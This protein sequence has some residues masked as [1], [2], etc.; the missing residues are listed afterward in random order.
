MP[1]IPIAAGVWPKTSVKDVAES[2][3]I[4]NLSD[5]AASALAADLEFRLNQIIEESIKFMRHAKRTKL[6]V[7][8]VD[9][10]LRAKN[11][12]PLW[13]FASTDTLSFRRTT[14][15][16][17][18]LYF[19]DDEEIDLTKIVNAQLPP[20]PRETSYTAHW[21]AVEGVQPAIP[22]N[23]SAAELK[24][25]PAF[26][27]YLSASRSDSKEEDEHKKMN[28]N[29]HLSRELRL[30][31]DRVTSA[32]SSEDQ[33][34][35]NAALASLSGDP[36]LHQL[37]PYLV[38]FVAEKVTH[39]LTSTSSPQLS[40]LR[41]SIH[42]LE[43]ILSN[44][45]LYL[46]PYLHQ[47][48]PS[49]LTCLLSSSFSSSPPTLEIEVRK[50]AASLL[51]TQVS[52]FQPFYPTLR[53]RILKTLAK[54]LISPKATDG[55]RLGAVIGIRALGMEATRV[56]LAQNL[57]AFGEC[58]E[59]DIAEG[60]LV[61][62][63]VQDLVKE[64]LSTMAGFFSSSE[65]TERLKKPKLIT[66]PAQDELEAEV[67]VLFA[68][69][70]MAS[71]DE[72][73]TKRAYSF[74]KQL[75]GNGSDSE[76]DVEMMEEDEQAPSAPSAPPPPPQDEQPKIEIDPPVETEIEKEKV[77]EKVVESMEEEKQ[78][79]KEKEVNEVE[80]ERQKSEGFDDDMVLGSDDPVVPSNTETTT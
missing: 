14:S 47:I 66:I 15:T 26:P 78:E 17:G 7:E 16:A 43:S 62:E 70:L 50:L 29:Q 20:I 44:S 60:K 68:A 56:I 13:G 79:E 32:A 30:Y 6:M 18:N 64:T 25:H 34:A 63:R 51:S 33:R 71:S 58:L 38:Q 3:G 37:V 42:I 21:L 61:E 2:L 1:M 22:Q 48:L 65:I 53:S 5:E 75:S 23:P 73:E 4:G 39:T 49:M 10:A 19:V 52:R 11:I 57:K 40:S 46:E 35:K 41:D 69:R 28:I 77:E 80:K 67:G 55:N 59:A 76:H 72:E 31:F 45:H 74:L 36:G 8:D 54:S 24:N 12:E 9:Y 27:A